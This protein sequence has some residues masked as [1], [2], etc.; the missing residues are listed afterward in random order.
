M[1][2]LLTPW[3]YLINSRKF[4]A[5]MKGIHLVEIKREILL[6]RI[7]SSESENEQPAREI[8]KNAYEM[9]KEKFCSG[10]IEP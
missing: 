7:L 5:R 4:P 3:L 10:A 6:Y 1:R 2:R 8:F 9:T